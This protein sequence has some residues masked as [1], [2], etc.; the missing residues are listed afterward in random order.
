[1]I[2][3][4]LGDAAL[5]IHLSPHSVGMATVTDLLTQGHADPRI[6]L[7]Y[8]RS[9]DRLSKSPAYTLAY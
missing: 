6:T 1:M 3:R 5:P 9:R 7:S 8:I 4:R 2:K